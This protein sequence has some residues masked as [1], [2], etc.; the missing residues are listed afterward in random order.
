MWL[1][2]N[3]NFPAYNGSSSTGWNVRKSLSLLKKSLSHPMTMAIVDEDGDEEME[4]D[5]EAVEKLC[6]QVCPEPPYPQSA[7][8]PCTK[9]KNRVNN[10]ESEETD[11]IMEDCQDE[12]S[13]S[14]K[15]NSPI[16]ISSGHEGVCAA[17]FFLNADAPV[18]NPVRQ[19]GINNE[20]IAS[21]K[22]NE[23]QAKG[24]A[25]DLS[26]QKNSTSTFNLSTGPCHISAEMNSPRVTASPTVD[27]DSRKTPRTSVALSASWKRKSRC[28]SEVHSCSRKDIDCSPT[29]YLEASLTRGLQ[30]L[31]SHSRHNVSRSRVLEFGESNDT[32]IETASVQR[33]NDLD[34]SQ[35]I[36]SLVPTD[37]SQATEKLRQNIPKVRYKHPSFCY[38][39]LV[40]V[41]CFCPL[42][43]KAYFWFPFCDDF[44]CNGAVFFSS[45]ISM[46]YI[47]AAANSTSIILF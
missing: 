45:E 43:C 40:Y 31:E 33:G 6:V 15:V 20:K 47:C 35:V 13:S 39:N 37:G 32:K 25:Q 3:G 19:A 42:F 30:L 18:L 38:S 4:I 29:N 9:L 26:G 1:K 17:K 2:S 41:Y 7:Q 28:E 46:L 10:L 12:V 5:E 8:T 11:V 16:A 23:L 24:F 22:D 27:H 14:D 44:H 21:P 34:C 36:S